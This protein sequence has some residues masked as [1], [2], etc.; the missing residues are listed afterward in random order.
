MKAANK[1]KD[2]ANAASNDLD[3]VA[4]NAEDDIGEL[5][6]G[7]REKELLYGEK[8][9]LKVYGPMIVAICASPRRYKVGPVVQ[10][11][12]APSTL[13]ICPYLQSLNCPLTAND[14]AFGSRLLP[15]AI[16]SARRQPGTHQAHVRLGAIL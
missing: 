10:P 16:P 8:S 3:A 1:D 4:G 7:I 15:V 11:H 9:L 12:L 6:A 14:I 2:T 5:I 13:L